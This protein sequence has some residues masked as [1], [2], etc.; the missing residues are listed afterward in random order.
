MGIS[1]YTLKRIFNQT[2]NTLIGGKVERI[3]LI[4]DNDFL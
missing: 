2:K 4:A 1:N 3:I